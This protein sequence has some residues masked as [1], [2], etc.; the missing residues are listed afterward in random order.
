MTIKRSIILPFML[1]SFLI[2][3]GCTSDNN[4]DNDQQADSETSQVTD[5]QDAEADSGEA[6]ENNDNENDDRTQNE[7]DENTGTSNQEPSSVSEQLKMKQSAV[8]LPTSFPTKED[9]EPQIEENS[10]TAYT[11]KYQ[12]SSGEEVATFSGTLYDSAED[13]SSAMNEFQSG[14]EVPS[15]D[16][17]AT[18]L[19]H[20]ITGYGEGATGH[21]YF[22]WQEGNWLFSISSLTQDNMDQPGIAKKMVDYLENHMLPAPDPTGAVLVDYPQG[23]KEVQVDIR[24]QEQDKIYRLTTDR[25]PL[26]ALEMA[27]SVK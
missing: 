15:Y 23:G 17:G 12:T 16:E 4:A 8:K 26:D 10:D 14:K 21:Q 6:T 19:G 1:G 11:V 3:A 7:T 2:A 13:A 20:G 5:N 24:W 25:V 22:S 9:V 27:T 18:D